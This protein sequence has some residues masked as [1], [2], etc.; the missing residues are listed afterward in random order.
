MHNIEVEQLNHVM[1]SILSLRMREEEEM[2]EQ[3][4][5]GGQDGV[6]GEE[7]EEQN[8]EDSEMRI[9]LDS[10]AVAP[11]SPTR[12]DKEGMEKAARARIEE[13][14]KE[15]QRQRQKKLGKNA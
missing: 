15:K 7:G 11:L 10:I 1:K 6:E 14:K 8:S 12:I 13:S 2:A 4:Q 5:R 9:I 3:K